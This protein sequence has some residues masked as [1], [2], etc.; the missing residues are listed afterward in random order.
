MCWDR[1]PRL[2]GRHVLPASSVRKAPAAEMAMKI[3][4][5]IARVQEDRVQA[6]PAGA[7]LPARPRAVAAQSGELLP[8]LA[9][10]GR[11]EQGGVLHPGVDGVGIGQRRFEMPDA[12]ELPGVRRAVVPLVRA[13]DAVVDELVADRLPG[14]AAVVGALDQL[15]EPA[16]GLRR[17]QPIRIDG[18][19]L[20]V[21]DLPAPEVG[22]ADV[23]PFALA[24]RRQDER[25]L[26]R[27]HQDP[28][29]AHVVL[30]VEFPKLLAG[31]I[32]I[33][34]CVTP[35]RDGLL[36]PHGCAEQSVP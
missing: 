14:L 3:R 33:G 23:P 18:R 35:T 10:V 19:S 12:L 8:R 36:A 7:R 9:A 5:G 1:S 24:V 32:W 6:H 28:Y 20:E 27:T 29:S 25:A 21:V 31:K 16:A 22:A 26:P 4:S 15:P 34:F 13:G 11:A 17:I 30:L 2:I